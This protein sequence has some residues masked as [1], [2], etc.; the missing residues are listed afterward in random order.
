M[1]LAGQTISHYR[2]LR[3]LGSGGMGV[4]YEAEDSRLNRRVALKFLSENPTVNPRAG[5]RFRREAQAASALNHPNICTVYDVGQ[6]GEESFIVMELLEGKTLRHAIAGKPLELTPLLE[7]AIQVADALDAAHRKG[8][9]HRDLKPENIFV[10]DRAQAKVLDFGLAKLEDPEPPDFGPSTPTLLE[11]LTHAGEAMGTIGYMS[12]EQALGQKVDA[13]TDLFSLGSVLYEMATGKQAFAGT[14]TAAIYD[15]ILNRT[16][17]PPV[18]VNP[19]LPLELE[20]IIGK[21]LEK[22]RDLR[23]Q[24]ASE[25]RTDLRRLKRNAESGAT[26]AGERRSG[27]R[28]A[29]VQRASSRGKRSALARHWRLPA[30]FLLLLVAVAGFAVW[31]L[32][33]QPAANPPALKL[34]QLTMNSND[35]PV[36]GGSISPDGKYLAY[37]DRQG[38]HIKVIATGELQLVPESGNRKTRNEWALGEWFPDAT[39]FLVNFA[40]PGASGEMGS[41]PLST[42]TVSVLGGPPRKLRDNA[43]ACSVTPDGSR[44]NFNTNFGSRGA[45]EIWV[46]SSTGEG[47][48]KLYETSGDAGIGCGG[49]FPDGKHFLSLTDYGPDK[50]ADIQVRD[51]NRGAPQTVLS[52]SDVNDFGLLRDGRLIYSRQ[53]ED[54]P[55]NCNFWEI[56]FSPSGNVLSQPRRL[57][58]W[59]GFCMSGTT[60]TADGK[61]LVFGEWR[62]QGNVFVADINKTGTRLSAPKTLTHSEGWDIPGAWT[63]DGKAVIF[64]SNRS[65]TSAIYKQAVDSDAAEPLVTGPDAHFAPL[66]SP[67]GRWLMYDVQDAHGDS[68]SPDRIMRIPIQGGPPELVLTLRLDGFRC[69]TAPATLCVLSQRTPDRKQVLFNAFD[70]IKGLGQEIDKVDT[71]PSLDYAWDLSPDGRLIAVIMRLSEGVIKIRSLADHRIWTIAVKDWN[72]LEDVTW[73]SSGKALFASMRREQN[74]ILLSI[75]LQGRAFV[76]WENRGAL[77]VYAVPASDGRRIA[78]FGQVLNQNMW[79]MEN[80]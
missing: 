7:L 8:I 40:P 42:W 33:S 17:A 26:L 49:W 27:F 75:D 28:S 39:R 74:S 76:L 59:A 72:E 71:D 35:N 4:V 10:T 68:K 67:D 12:P 73:Q 50:P 70:P 78:M 13:R 61:K 64:T 45:R 9:I 21:A 38:I 22:D 31:R 51:V 32:K 57:T 16:P 79:M 66:V 48:S 46:M 18:D 69:A 24:V 20:D 11:S 29:A 77:R 44:I 15:G 2:L 14:T 60:A 23:Y 37:V 53:E 58:S 30:S 80:F 63:P 47:A 34:R 56:R 19:A 52:V 43:A 5:E 65:G 55:G 25:I 6:H 1:T 3:K 36:L 41:E 54:S 62:G